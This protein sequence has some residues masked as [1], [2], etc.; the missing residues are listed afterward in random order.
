MT[1]ITSVVKKESANV[2][3]TENYELYLQVY[4]AAKEV[5]RICIRCIM[6]ETRRIVM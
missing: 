6:A 4:D 3:K 1:V 2:L 5:L